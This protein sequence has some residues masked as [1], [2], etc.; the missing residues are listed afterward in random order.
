MATEINREVHDPANMPQKRLLHI[1]R[2]RWMH[3]HQS[4]AAWYRLGG[5][6]TYHQFLVLS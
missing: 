2:G 6:R 4:R 1:S 3:L 5:E